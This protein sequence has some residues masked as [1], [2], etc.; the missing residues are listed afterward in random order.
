MSISLLFKNRISM[1]LLQALML[2]F[3]ISLLGCKGDSS[4]GPEQAPID[5]ERTLNSLKKMDDYPFYTMRYY[6]NYGFKQYLETGNYDYLWTPTSYDNNN[7]FF[8]TCFAAMGSDSCRYF[9]RNFDWT[10]HVAL[11]LYTDSPDGFASI[12]MVNLEPIGFSEGDPVESQVNRR[13]LLRSATTPVDG[14]NECGVAIGIMLVDYM[15]PPYDPGKV[16]IHGGLL[17][18]LVLDYAKNSEDAVELIRNYNFD[19][20]MPCHFLISDSSGNSLVVEFLDNE[21]KITENSEKWQ[22]CTNTILFGNQLPQ[23][24]DFQYYDADTWRRWRYAKAYEILNEYGGNITLNGAMDILSNTA[25]NFPQD[26]MFTMWS[27]VYNQKA[28]SVDIVID[29]DYSEVY[30]FNLNNFK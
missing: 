9:G 5:Q 17:V 12:S 26:N 2:L 11:L 3:F 21:L 25:A 28:L 15:H 30:H 4:T 27:A 10:E 23:K 8:C 13:A 24:A 18:R 7:K 1:V 29:R 6:G 19:D 16:T 22:V 20:P 14:I